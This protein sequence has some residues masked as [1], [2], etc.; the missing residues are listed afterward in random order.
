ML[1]D[2]GVRGKLFAVLAIPTVLL[3]VA[4]GWLVGGQVQAARQAGQIEAVTDVALQLNRVVHSLQLER[5]VTLD[6]L[7][8][9]TRRRPQRRAGAAAVHELPAPDPATRRSPPLPSNTM[10]ASIQAAAARSAKAHTELASV[11][12]SI[13]PGTF[14]VG[15]DG[16][17]VRQDDRQ[18]P[19]AAGR[20]RRVGVPELAQR[21]QAEQAL[22]TTIESALTRARPDRA[23]LPRRKASARRSSGR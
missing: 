21:L 9:V 16:R 4:S 11:R 10:S 23:R 17:R 7:Q 2:A 6:Y 8:G 13:D 20:D 22:S 12:K 15:R 19:S 18:R 3:V 1:R 5:T 14:A